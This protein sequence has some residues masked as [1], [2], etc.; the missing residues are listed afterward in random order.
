MPI[1]MRICMTCPVYLLAYIHE[2]FREML[3]HACIRILG[4]P[5]VAQNEAKI[6]QGPQS[7]LKTECVV[8][9]VSIGV[10]RWEPQTNSRV[11]FTN[12]DPP[13]ISVLGIRSA[14]RHFK[15]P[16]V[17]EEQKWCHLFSWWAFCLWFA[18]DKNL[19][20]TYLELRGLCLW[21]TVPIHGSICPTVV[22]PKL[23]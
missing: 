16:E 23:E 10:L 18:S 19:A 2:S 14:K 12:V 9:D 3:R 1:Y 11:V 5:K 6:R 8:D 17:K 20:Y 15:K 7:S 22:C 21:D 13:K 4:A